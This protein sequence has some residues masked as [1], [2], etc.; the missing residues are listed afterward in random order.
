M[1]VLQ[2][3]RYECVL[4]CARADFGVSAFLA[5]GTRDAVRHTFVGT[6]C[7]M[8]PEVIEAVRSQL[9]YCTIY[10][11]NDPQS[12][13]HLSSASTRLLRSLPSASSLHCASVLLPRERTHWHTS[14][15]LVESSRS[16]IYAPSAGSQS[17]LARLALRHI[18]RA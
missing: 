15:V 16:R 1:L 7:W 12:S 13:P 6:P 18:R 17:S 2:W 11:P 9:L 10:P 3:E 4:C 5:L 8:A 14:H